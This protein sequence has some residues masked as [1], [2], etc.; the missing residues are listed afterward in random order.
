[1]LVQNSLR[2]VALDFFDL[3]LQRL[4]AL[5]GA[6][7]NST[8]KQTKQN[9][10]NNKTK[11]NKQQNKRKQTTKQNKTN[12]PRSSPLQTSRTFES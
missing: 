10:T 2:R 4:R 5:K 1:L 12:T 6:G 9:K 3:L 8:N 11:E 7:N